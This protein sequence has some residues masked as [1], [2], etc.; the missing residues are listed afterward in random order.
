MSLLQWP[1]YVDFVSVTTQKCGVGK[2]GRSQPRSYTGYTGSYT[3]V[4][5]E[6]Y[7]IIWYESH[8]AEAASGG[9]VRGDLS[10]K[11]M[12][13]LRLENEPC[14]ERAEEIKDAEAFRQQG[15]RCVEGNWRRVGGWWVRESRARIRK[16]EARNC[17]SF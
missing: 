12:F 15:E 1:N 8:V 14:W 7:R 6:I 9:V 4:S 5:L 11:V 17:D 10:E 3:G 16:P 2:R 13:G